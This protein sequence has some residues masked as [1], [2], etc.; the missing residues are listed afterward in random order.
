M[1]RTSGGGPPLT[2]SSKPRWRAKGTRGGGGGAVACGGDLDSDLAQWERFPL[3]DS[4][5]IPVCVV[6][7]QVGPQSQERV[8]AP[9]W[10]VSYYH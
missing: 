6:Y 5:S 4:V 7:T 8:D 1:I 9:G 3:L 10:T 2:A